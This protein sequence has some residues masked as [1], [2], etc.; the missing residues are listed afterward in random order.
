MRSGDSGGGA[1]A[2]CVSGVCVRR[3]RGRECWNTHA[4]G[5]GGWRGCVWRGCCAGAEYRAAALRRG[6]GVLRAQ[7]ASQDSA[8]FRERHLDKEEWLLQP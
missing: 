1:S 5:R 7:L 4:C 3:E 6:R 2:P 8:L